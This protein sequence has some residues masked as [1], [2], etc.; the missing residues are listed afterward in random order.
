MVANKISFSSLIMGDVK[1]PVGP[2]E[3]KNISLFGRFY[4]LN[5]VQSGH[6][7]RA[8]SLNP[9]TQSRPHYIITFKFSILLIK[10]LYRKKKIFFQLTVC[11]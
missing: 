3:S 6:L 5:F 9:N 1:N 2:Y 7:G 11:V 8:I 4:G 10:K